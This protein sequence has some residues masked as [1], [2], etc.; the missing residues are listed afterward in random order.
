VETFGEGQRGLLSLGGAK[1]RDICLRRLRSGGQSNK[2]ELGDGRCTSPV[3]R[4]KK[5]Y[6][7]E[8]VGGVERAREYGGAPPKC[9]GWGRVPLRMRA[10]LARETVY[11][12]P[13]VKDC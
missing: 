3:S 1:I 5:V 6:R 9:G 10:C 11:L 12:T 13:L 7:M 8:G 4:F 2:V